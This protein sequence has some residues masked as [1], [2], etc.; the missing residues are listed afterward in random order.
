MPRIRR[1]GTAVLIFAIGAI[2]SASL[3]TYIAENL[4]YQPPG[5]VAD[6]YTRESYDAA[7]MPLAGELN[8]SLAMNVAADQSG[9]RLIAL[10]LRDADLTS[11]EDLGRQIRSLRA[12]LPSVDGFEL[13]ATAADT[14]AVRTFLE[15]ERIGEV[16][17]RDVEVGTILKGLED[18]PTPA[19]LVLGGGGKLIEGI[20]HH[21]RFR[22]LRPRSF[23]EELISIQPSATASPVVTRQAH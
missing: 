7:T 20:A 15:L 6:H 21:Q 13:W 23:A 5:D 4:A 17:M 10:V 16:E 9:N 11:C 12:T 8:D 14:A 19:A 1:I 22:N 18:L 2:S 3:A